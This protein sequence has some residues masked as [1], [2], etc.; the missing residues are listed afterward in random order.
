MTNTRSPSSNAERFSTSIRPTVYSPDV[1]LYCAPCAFTYVRRLEGKKSGTLRARVVDCHR[2]HQN[3]LHG[4]KK[5]VKSCISLIDG[6]L[7][8]ARLSEQW[9]K[10]VRE[11]TDRRVFLTFSAQPV[12]LTLPRRSLCC[13]LLEG[14]QRR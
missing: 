4:T 6:A 14:E 10:E 12:V 11:W 2:L 1:P 8:M 9:G 7:K 13:R 3:Q 5:S